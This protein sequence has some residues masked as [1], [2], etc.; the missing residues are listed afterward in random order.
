MYVMTTMTLDKELGIQTLTLA[1]SAITKKILERGGKID[2]KMSP[3]VVSAREETELQIMMD[4]LAQENAEQDGDEDDD[5]DAD[6][7]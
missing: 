2:I 1:I 5:D 4:R 3:K 7:R 6:C